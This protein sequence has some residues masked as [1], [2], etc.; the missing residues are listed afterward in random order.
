M[1]SS[2]LIAIVLG[3]PEEPAMLRA[4][5]QAA[6]L[7][8]SAATW[9]EAHLVIEGLRHSPAARDRFP[10]LLDRLRLE[11]V[12]V[13]EELAGIARI[14]NLKYGRGHNPAGLNF[15]DGFSHALAKQTG[16]PLLFKSNDF[17][18]TDIVPALP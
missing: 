18:Q 16:E 1:D 5:V 6:S 2:A 15:G 14:G 8:I 7:K 4:M 13:D 9:L 10:D 3:E 17:S 11:T 12:P